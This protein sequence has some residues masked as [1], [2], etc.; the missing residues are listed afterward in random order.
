MHRSLLLVSLIALALI[1]APAASGAI[2][3]FGTHVTDTDADEIYT[4]DTTALTSVVVIDD[5]GDGRPDVDEPV[6]LLKSGT[7]IHTTAVRLAYPMTSELGSQVRSGDDDAGRSGTPLSGQLAYLDMDGDQAFTPGDFLFYD[8]SGG[9]QGQVSV[10]DLYLTGPRAG[11]V[12]T[13]ASSLISRS[14]TTV[15]GTWGVDDRDGNGFDQG[16][17]VYIDADDDG[18]ISVSD[19]RVGVD[20][21]SLFGTW[22]PVDASRITLPLSTDNP[23]DS[24]VSSDSDGDGKVDPDEPVFLSRSTSQVL[25]STVRLHGPITGEVGTLVEGGDSDLGFDVAEIP[26]TLSFDGTGDIGADEPLIFDHDGSGSGTGNVNELI[27]SG[28]EAGSLIDGASPH[29]GEDLSQAPGTISFLD[30]DGDGSFGLHDVVYLDADD[31]GFVSAGDVQLSVYTEEVLDMEDPET[32]EPQQDDEPTD[33]G[34]T[35]EDPAPEPTPDNSSDDE[36]AGPSDSDGDGVPDGQDACP[37]HAAQ[38]DDGCPVDGDGDG[39]PDDED[40]CP[41][42]AAV[43]DDG[44]PPDADGDG[45]FDRDDDCPDEVGATANAG[46]PEPAS[47]DDD[48]VT[49]EDLDE[50]RQDSPSPGL[51]VVLAALSGMAAA[52]VR[53]RAT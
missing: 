27:L 22:P 7:N 42:V 47:A 1:L 38:T 28:Q 23:P 19:V 45:V 40:A 2:G 26:G 15:S 11:E 50:D 52:L 30:T 6:L 24:F 18:R 44:C 51:L 29:Q 14:L 16:D 8:L 13:S 3:S 39:I 12:V 33:D 43:T 36:P 31:D 21:A 10:G 48:N 20:T 53:R 41:E 37:N 25:G 34:D 17:R 49:D 9:H 4:L 46:C 32:Q 5:D 35:T